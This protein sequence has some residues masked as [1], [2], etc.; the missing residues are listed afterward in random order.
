M[1][2]KLAIGLTASMAMAAFVGCNS[3]SDP[4]NIA[5]SSTAIRTFSLTADTSVCQNLDSV[6]FSIDLVQGV[7]FNA[8]SLPYGTDVSKLIPKIT[9]LE[10]ASILELTVKRDGRADTTYNYLTNSSDTIDF[11]HPVAL[12]IASYD[13]T[14]TR[15]YTIRVN[16]HRMRPDSLTWDRVDRRTL[17]SAFEYPSRQ[18]TTRGGDKL[19][20]LTASGQQYCIATSPDDLASLNDPMAVLSNW[21]L[22]TPQ[23][24]F[25][26]D[27]TSFTATDDALFI[28]SEAGDLYKSADGGAS[29]TNTG[30]NL[31]AII[32]GYGSKL[33]GTAKVGAEWK[34][35]AYPEASY[36]DMPEGM[37]VSGMSVPV[38]TKFAMSANPQLLFLGGR[39]EDGSLS[40][41]SWGFDGYT[42]TKVSRR[43][44]PCGGVEGVTIVPYY[45]FKVSTSWNVTTYPSIL[46]F[47]GRLRDGSLNTTV[48]RSDDYGFTWTLAPALMQLPDFIPAFYDAQAYVITSQLE[49]PVAVPAVSKPV[50]S[51]DCPYIYLFGGRNAEGV[52]RNTVWRGVVNRL[53]FKPI[54]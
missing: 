10:G 34:I 38:V 22:I 27:V 18:H 30:H 11:T 36:T 19:Y 42:W 25:S 17:P 33:F 41:A 37:P 12:R 23:F 31:H 15:D 49:A 16:V 40:D 4:I 5:A 14:A 20:C 39:L 54:V 48:Y 3:D 32:G 29:W 51:W 46:A 45:T 47:G 2:R 28:L 43:L 50:E 13:G 8:D 21:P 6:Y 35:F 9:P 1:I 24:G 7:I 44:L 52:T 26:P 53:S